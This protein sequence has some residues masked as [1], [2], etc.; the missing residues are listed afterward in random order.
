MAASRLLEEPAV[1]GGSDMATRAPNDRKKLVLD[2]EDQ[3]LLKKKER[4]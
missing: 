3:S 2:F 1:E 4:N